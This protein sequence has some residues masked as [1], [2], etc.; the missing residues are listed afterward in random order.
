MRDPKLPMT[1]HMFTFKSDYLQERIL[2]LENC[3]LLTSKLTKTFPTVF[4]TRDI[5]CESECEIM[6]VE[7]FKKESFDPRMRIKNAKTII[8]TT[9]PLASFDYF[10]NSGMQCSF[11]FMDQEKILE[12]SEDLITQTQE[13]NIDSTGR[14]CSIATKTS[15]LN[16]TSHQN[17]R[18]LNPSDV[19]LNTILSQE[20]RSLISEQP[21]TWGQ[22]PECSNFYFQEDLKEASS[23]SSTPPVYTNPLLAKRRIMTIKK[24]FNE[25]KVICPQALATLRE[26]FL[27]SQLDCQTN[28]TPASPPPIQCYG[29]LQ[30]RYNLKKALK[31][32]L[33]TRRFFNKNKR[34]QKIRNS[35]FLRCSFKS[36]QYSHKV[37]SHSTF[38]DDN[39]SPESSDSCGSSFVVE[40]TEN[41]YGI[42]NTED[43]L[44]K[45]RS[46]VSN[47]RKYLKHSDKSLN[48]RNMKKGDLQRLFR[49][50]DDTESIDSDCGSI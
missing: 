5:N 35:M 8:V 10:V 39:N 43:G 1:F 2:S 7:I 13:V 17:N 23:S 24:K 47:L 50:E 15:L 20:E 11:V 14:K 48:R 32:I 28:L 16:H 46:V 34:M 40:T 19:I 30:R 12:A 38:P 31:K 27:I 42:F 41:D 18:L 49:Y 26:D 6:V 9:T 21:K 44:I 25:K 3:V 36:N 22:F 45:V 33:D 4:F 29:R 37:S